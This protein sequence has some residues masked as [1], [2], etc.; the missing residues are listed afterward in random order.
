MTLTNSYR[1]LPFAPPETA[2]TAVQRSDGW[3]IPVSGSN[4]DYHHF[5]REWEAGADVLDAEGSPVPFT[6]PES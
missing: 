6:P 1:F 3:T 5:L 2:P 4:P